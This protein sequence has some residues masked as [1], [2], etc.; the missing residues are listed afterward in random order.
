MFRLFVQYYN[1]PDAERQK[2][3]DECLLKNCQN[4]QIGEIFIFSESE[5][6]VGVPKPK[7]KH[8]VTGNERLSFQWVIDYANLVTRDCDYNILCNSDIILES[9]IPEFPDP[10][11][12]ALTR[13]GDVPMGFFQYAYASQDTW[14]WKGINKIKTADFCF[15]VLGC[16]N[17]LAYEAY[18]AGY[19]VT[20][21][22]KT[23]RTVHRHQT[24][25][26]TPEA[27]DNRYRLPR[28]YLYLTPTE[29]KI[30]N[31]TSHYRFNRGPK[32]E[33][34]EG[35]RPT[36]PGQT[37]LCESVDIFKEGKKKVE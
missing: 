35:W 10:Y 14:I 8:V 28:P 30:T 3:L 9:Q 23:I 16:D 32:V 15:G 22:S 18:E 26:R 11:F 12:L 20:N 25:I 33:Q 19:Y 13:Y 34:S 7:V 17:K 36:E 1:F 24:K 2:E 4:G 21:P 29:Y 37:P 6:P 27:S 31:D 5:P